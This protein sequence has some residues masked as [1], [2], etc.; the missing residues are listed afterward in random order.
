MVL[1]RGLDDRGAVF[2]TNAES[3]KGRELLDNPRAAL[4]FHWEP[5][6][7][8]VRL[9]GPVERVDDEE[10][11]AYFASRPLPSRLG[12]WASDQSRPIESREALM[13]RYAEAAARF[14]DGP[15]PR[16][17]Y[18][19]GFRVV[20]DAVEFWEHGSHRLHDRIRYTRAGTSWISE[21]LAP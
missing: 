1:L 20:P 8:Q 12:A 21:R 4:V 14:G 2:Y 19:Y 16:P 7:R 9:E 3:R 6:G 11:D 15:V 5:L 17:D 13:E 18:W 10:S